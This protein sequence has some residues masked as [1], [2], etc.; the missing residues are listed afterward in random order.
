MDKNTGPE[1]YTAF[2][3]DDL[4]HT[5]RSAPFLV[6]DA[7][8]P[9]PDGE[10]LALSAGRGALYLRFDIPCGCPA[11]DYP[12]RLVVRAGGETLAV[13][14][15]VRV[16][17][18][19]VP[20]ERSLQLSNWYSLPNIA[21]R[22]RLEPWS[23]SFWE[24]AER[25]AELMARTRQTHFL[26]PFCAAEWSRS[27]GEWRF[28]FARVER[29]AQ[30]FLSHGFQTLEGGPAVRQRF[31]GDPHFVLLTDE[32][33]PAASREGLSF[34]E[35][36]FRAF[37]AFLQAHGWE[38]CCVQHVADE[39]FDSS[40]GEYALLAQRMRPLL[41]GVP[42][43][44]AVCTSKLSGGPDIPIP[45]ARRY[46]ADRSVFSGLQQAGRPVWFYTCALPGGAYCNRL[47][48]LPLLKTR[49]LHWG[50]A[51]YGLSGYLHWGFNCY[52]EGQNPYGDLSPR[53]AAVH[54][55]RYLPPG[56]THLVYPGADRPL[57]SVR[58]EQMRKGVE[59]YELLR[60]LTRHDP[61][62]AETIIRAVF[63]D[64]SD[65]CDS[66]RFSGVYQALLAACSGGRP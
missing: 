66:R 2:P 20:Q 28:S 18:V 33:I 35:G 41:P 44:D 29:L 10:S 31:L 39:P 56:D 11:G 55:E 25:Y 45:D 40:I 65:V 16:Y 47:L 6:Y 58:L 51:R 61:R 59:D 52:R 21:S 19:S 12:F 7:L 27:G 34:L 3:G 49:L 22:H 38:K 57:A 15:A 48:D 50:N 30:L 14:I 36:Y 17:A 42:F 60:G 54:E 5:V 32:N 4:S 23:E 62:R 43:L 13:E 63:R 37:Y 53:F 64:F 1:G 26:L 24:M 9:L 46:E 8:F